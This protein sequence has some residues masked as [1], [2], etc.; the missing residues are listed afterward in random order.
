M[1]VVLENECKKS[2]ELIQELA[3]IKII[4]AKNP[5]P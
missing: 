3:I 1:R 4:E 5:N 2:N